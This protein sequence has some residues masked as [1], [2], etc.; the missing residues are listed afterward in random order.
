VGGAAAVDVDVY[1]PSGGRE[2]YKAI[3]ADQLVTLREGKG[4]VPN[5]GWKRT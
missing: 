3:D 1:W 4:I 5:K 2:T